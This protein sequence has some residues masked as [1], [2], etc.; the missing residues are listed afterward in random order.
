MPAEITSRR[1]FLHQTLAFSAASALLGPLTACGSGYVAGAE[2]PFETAHLL[3][4]GDW[5]AV[6]QHSDQTAV[7]AAMQAYVSANNLP[8]HTLLMLGDNFYGELGSIASLRW[9]EQ[10]ETMYP[11]T[12]FNCPAYAI[13]GNHDY[14]EDNG[15][16]RFD[17][18]LDYART[19]NTRWKMPS[20]FYK[21]AFPEKSPLI[22][23][24]ALDSN[25]PFPDGSTSQGVFLTMTADQRQAQLDWLT[26]E[27]NKP[28]DTPFVAVMGHH[29]LYS[30]GPHG[31]NEGLI[32][33]WDSL[34]RE[35]KVHLYLA[36]HDHDLQHLEFEGHPTSFFCSGGGGA[37]LYN[38]VIQPA[39]RGPYAQKVF[40]FSHLE[41]TPR[42]M[43]L[44]HIDKTG[45]VLHAFAKTPDNK[46]SLL[47]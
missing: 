41:V 8:I 38:L 22:T 17:V 42:H 11:S 35:H 15:V 18:E 13:P 12:V 46:I 39:S 31:D 2:D 26:A 19:M 1:R 32:H 29:P 34:F 7:A 21:F 14:I 36:G 4:V 47:T 45:A 27:L 33:D 28:R 3:M 16:L 6:N 37:D 44:R 43:T 5:G 25:I 23:I 20:Q 10:F 30:D 9:K 40:G 24:I